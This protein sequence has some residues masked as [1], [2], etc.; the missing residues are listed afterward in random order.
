LTASYNGF[1]N[2]ED[3]NV[4]NGGPDLSTTADT[5]SPVGGYPITVTQGTLNNA[6]YNFSFHDGTMTVLS[7]PVIASMG[8]TNGTVIITWTSFPGATYR[9]QYNDNLSDTNWNDVSPDV[10]ATGSTTTQTNL[11]GDVPQRYYR[12]WLLAF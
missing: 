5:G 8:L 10:M 7:A 2:N 6:N 11:L 12:V 4:L 9:V 3:T 1:V